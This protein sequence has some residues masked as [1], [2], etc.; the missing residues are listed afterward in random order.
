MLGGTVRDPPGQVMAGDLRGF[1][2]VE[3]MVSS[4]ERI[5]D[6]ALQFAEDIRF[7]VTR[8]PLPRRWWPAGG[9]TECSPI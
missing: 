5:G 4:L 1:I 8:R 7:M 6:H 2:A 9:V 3:R